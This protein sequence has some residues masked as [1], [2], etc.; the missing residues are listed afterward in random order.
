MAVPSCVCPLCA[1]QDD[2]DPPTLLADDVWQFVCRGHHKD[3]P[4]P[5]AFEVSS[6]KE[7]WHESGGLATELGL[8]EDLPAALVPGE[9][10]V[11]YGVVEYRYA[12]AHP[13]EYRMLV[14]TYGHTSSGPKRYTASVYIA[15]TL[16]ALCR[17]GIVSVSSGRGTGYWDYNSRISYWALSGSP[18]ADVEPLTWSTVA[19]S[20]GIN[21]RDWPPLA[22]HAPT[23]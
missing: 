22:Y 4:S 1:L 10:F 7:V 14:D 9:P 5:Y 6:K 8:W 20:L 16:G 2:L 3:G 21:A 23:P 12:V 15:K 11:E 17:E 19:A 13:A 18:A